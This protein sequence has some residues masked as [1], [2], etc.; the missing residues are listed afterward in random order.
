MKKLITTLSV[1]ALAV[2][3]PCASFAQEKK[4]GAGAPAEKK[5]AAAKGTLPF[6]G[7]VSEV[8]AAAKTFKTKNKDGKENTFTITDKTQILHGDAT[9]A[10][11]ADIK[12]EEMVRGSRVKTGDNQWEAVKVIIGAKPG[13]E[14]KAGGEGKGGGEGKAKKGEAKVEE[15]KKAE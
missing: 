4:E 6:Q 2:S 9:A 3:V 15:P 12:P 13:G 8:D 5:E 7:K 11:I 14:G 10:T 1:L